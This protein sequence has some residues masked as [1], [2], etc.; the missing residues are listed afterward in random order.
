M[1]PHDFHIS[2]VITSY[3][4][5][6]Y[7]V[8]AV[9]SV[10]HQ[11]TRPVEIIIADDHSTDGS[12]EL[13]REYVVNYPGWI[14]GVFQTENVGIPRNRN[15]AL[16]QV[17]G[18]YVAIL[19]GDDR[20]LPRKLEREIEALRR[21]PGAQCVYSNVQF[22]D[23][24][25]QRL[26]VRDQA[27]QPSGDVFVY[28]ARGKFGLL[29]SMLI[30]YTVLE[31]VGYL[32][33]RLPKY[34]GFD[35]TVQLTK[36]SQFAYVPDPLA[37]YRIHPTSDSKGYG[38]EV[39][40]YDLDRIYEKL[41]PL[42]ADLSIAEKHDIKKS[43]SHLFF[44]LRLRETLERGAS[45]E[46]LFVSLLGLGRGSANLGDLRKM[47]TSVTPE[48]IRRTLRLLRTRWKRDTA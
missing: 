29:R 24:E 42:L 8:Q 5:K 38:A 44:R 6:E 39:H 30:D 19:D 20:F 36:R 7:L 23:P 32:D 22:I 34:D 17:I 2:V 1:K 10:I 31:D 40:L 11:T 47:V 27:E 16:R 26:G 35:L 25:G 48:P 4:H 28:V 33:A 15:A 12:V 41:L 45:V 18:N 14:K 13:I 43:W 3:D 21:Y 9:D 37:E 46:A